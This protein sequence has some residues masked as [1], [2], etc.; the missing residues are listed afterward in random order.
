MSDSAL[1]DVFT[2]DELARA[3]GVPVAAVT[4]LA[5]EGSLHPVPGTMF[6]DAVRA[7]QSAAGLRAAAVAAL[8]P[9]QRD[10]LFEREASETTVQT[11][12]SLAAASAVHIMLIVLVA[13]LSW[14]SSGRA[15]ALPVEEPPQLVFLMAPGPGGG[16]GGSGARERMPAARLER[17]GRAA[18][19]VSTPEATPDPVLTAVRREEPPQ[20][21]AEAVKPV[22]LPPEPLA[23]RAVIAPVVVAAASP[24]EQPGE[25]K[26]RPAESTSRGAGVG[27]ESGSG[28]GDGSGEGTG[29]GI[30]P[31]SGGGAGG[32]PYRPGSGIQ[33][34]RLLREVKAE[35]T[36]EARRRGL[37][38][39]VV[40]EIVVTRDGRVGTVTV[41]RG[42]GSGLDERA[43][44][45]V[46]QWQFAP[47]TRLGE[48][49]DVVV[50]VAVEFTMR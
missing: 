27:S 40:L 14:G 41:L 47:A 39:D 11:R 15:A 6:F 37:T 17:A 34:P 31:G 2:A 25:I 49:I 28:R 23:S 7:L 22:E 12:L 20:P 42:M 1:A 44:A 5:A 13:V 30:G 19:Q 45:A 32:G 48:A 9:P 24:R 21:V 26:P 50:E 36:E 43:A 18:A 16:G 46:R 10:A 38:G 8:R 33:P 35:Y 29:S 4:A 3:V